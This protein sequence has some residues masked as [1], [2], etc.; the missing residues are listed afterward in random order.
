MAFKT[1]AGSAKTE[2]KEDK[3]QL[4]FFL[5]GENCKPKPRLRAIDSFDLI[6]REW[7]LSMIYIL[8]RMATLKCILQKD[9]IS[10][11]HSL[12]MNVL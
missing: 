8:L 12:G 6:D 10:A 3:T 7:Q 2:K 9:N 11:H 4:L 1:R 5:L